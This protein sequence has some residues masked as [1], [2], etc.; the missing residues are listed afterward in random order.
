LVLKYFT[1]VES[2][3]I[4]KEI[5]GLPAMGGLLVAEIFEQP[6]VE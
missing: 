3:K 6:G 5:T 2:S 1:I 4:S